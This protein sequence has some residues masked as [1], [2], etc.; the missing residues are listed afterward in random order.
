MGKPEVIWNDEQMAGRT[1]DQLP[2]GTFLV[3]YDFNG[4]YRLRWL[5]RWVS[6]LLDGKSCQETIATFDRRTWAVEW[7]QSAA[8]SVVAREDAQ[9]LNIEYKSGFPA[10][11]V[12]PREPQ[13]D[14]REE[15]QEG[16]DR[17]PEGP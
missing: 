5:V 9:A 7:A 17:S 13:G 16:S 1:E 12:D 2:L 3:K 10:R 14:R 15:L 4:S 8:D 11:I 6:C